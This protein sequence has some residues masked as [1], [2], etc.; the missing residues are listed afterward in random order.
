MCVCVMCK[1]CIWE[2]GI[3]GMVCVCGVLVYMQCVS[4]YAMCMWCDVYVY[5]VCMYRERIRT[6]YL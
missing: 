3:C 4:M 2:C 6:A 1:M 5:D